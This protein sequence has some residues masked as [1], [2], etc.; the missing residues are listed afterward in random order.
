ME[1]R[2]RMTK[3]QLL[4][5]VDRT[6]IEDTRILARNVLRYTLDNVIHVRYCETDIIKIDKVTGNTTLTSGGTYS[7]TSKR[8]I[9]RFQN[10]VKVMQRSGIWYI[11]V[12]CWSSRPFFDGITIT[13]DGIVLN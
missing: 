4:A 10:V 9:N 13:P 5:S 2:N 12:P 8:H 11:D 3:K 1:L 6:D 7:Q